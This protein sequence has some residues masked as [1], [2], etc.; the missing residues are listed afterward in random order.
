MKFRWKTFVNFDTQKGQIHIT[1]ERVKNAIV[2]QGTE[3][4]LFKITDT[5][6]GIPEHQIGQLFQPFV[7]LDN[8]KTVEGTGLG[9]VSDDVI[10]VFCSK[11]MDFILDNLS[12]GKYN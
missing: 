12:M 6:K 3:E 10:V 4:I 11:I 8:S 7:Q 5:G 9:L 1:A 2:E